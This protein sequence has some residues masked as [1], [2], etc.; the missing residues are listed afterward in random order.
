MINAINEAHIPTNFKSVKLRCFGGVTLDDMYFK[1]IRL[2]R[3][4]AIPV[5]FCASSNN[6]PN[7]T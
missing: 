5:A 6:S 3:K 1:L 4:Q 7:E 2:L